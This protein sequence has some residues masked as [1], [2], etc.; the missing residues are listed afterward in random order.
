[1][2]KTICTLLHETLG[3]ENPTSFINVIGGILRYKD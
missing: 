3:D 2:A 1:M